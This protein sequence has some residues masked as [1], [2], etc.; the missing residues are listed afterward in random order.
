MK[1]MRGCLKVPSRAPVRDPSKGSI[2]DWSRVVRLRSP[3]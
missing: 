1:Y 2:R 3:L